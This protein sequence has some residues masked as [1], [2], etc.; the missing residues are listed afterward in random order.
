VPLLCRQRRIS[1][2]KRPARW[3]SAESLQVINRSHPSTLCFAGLFGSKKVA[4]V[5]EE[6]EQ[7]VVEEEVVEVVVAKPSPLA[8]LFSF[9]KL[10]AAVQQKAEEQAVKEEV[11]EEVEEEEVVAKPSPFASLFSFGAKPP[12]AVQQKEEEEQEQVRLPSCSCGRSLLHLSAA[13]WTLA[14]PC[15]GPVLALRW[16]CAGPALALR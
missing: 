2:A 3:D 9:A 11:E 8:G 4:V 7:V 10:P 13:P 6:E 12:A 1:R 14:W 15:A 16:P 5:E